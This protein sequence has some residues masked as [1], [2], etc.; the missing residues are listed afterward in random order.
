MRTLVAYVP[1]LHEGYRRFFEKYKGQKELYIF[2]PEITKEFNWLRK[3][4]RALDPHV[5][6]QAIEALGIFKKV[7]ILDTKN[8]KQIKGVVVMPDEDISRTLAKRYFKN[9]KFDPIFLRWDKTNSVLE[10]KI[11]PHRNV[12]MRRLFKEAAESSD[13]WRRVGAAILKGKKIILL[14]HNRHLPSDQSHYVHGDP[15]NNFHKGDHIEI[16]TAFHAEASLIAEAAKRGV[17]LSGL[18]MYVSTF[19]CPPCAKLIAHSGIKT[20]YYAE[21]YSVLD[22]E[23]ILKGAGV[24]LVFVK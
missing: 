4:I 6:Q 5:M 15:R 21:G 2:G 12:L 7:S 9:A 22:G 3:D 14:A 20:L 8:F 16:S 19:P 23:E 13:M 18:D 10:K 1:V 17:K 11:I 24:R